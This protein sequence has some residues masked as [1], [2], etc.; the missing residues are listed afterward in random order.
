[1]EAGRP[2]PPKKERRARAVPRILAPRG[3][4][5]PPPHGPGRPDYLR[6]LKVNDCGV[7]DQARPG[8]PRWA[9]STAR[10]FQDRREDLYLAALPVTLERFR[11]AAQA[12]ATE[13]IIRT[14][15]GRDVGGTNTWA[16]NTARRVHEAVPDRGANCSCGSPNQTIITLGE[17]TTT[18]MSEPDPQRGAA[19]SSAAAGTPV[20]LEGR[21]PLA[22]R[23]LLYGGPVPTPRFSASCSTSP[24][25]AGG[26]ITKQPVL[27]PGPRGE[28][29]P[30]PSAAT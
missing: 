29:G 27:V 15:A 9:S 2:F 5:L 10:E 18:S 14:S 20:T 4:R 16:F 28:P 26:Q 8:G 3:P 6:A 13:Q 1:M 12:F 25:R 24:S 30:G 19:P 23:N 22:E 21:S 11:F 7:P 17:H